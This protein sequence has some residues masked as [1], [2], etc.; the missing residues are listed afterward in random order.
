[1]SKVLN[2][3]GISQR[4]ILPTL[5]TTFL[6]PSVLGATTGSDQWVAPEMPSW[7]VPAAFAIL[8][9]VYALIIFELV[10]RALAA[11][12]GGVVVVLALHSIGD[13]P[14]LGT[15]VTWIDEETIGLLIGM[16]VIVDILGKTG[17]FQW[18]AVQAYALSGG[19]IW[20]L[21]IILCT[22]TAVFS[23]FL[24]NVT[25]ILLIVPVTIQIARVLDI[26]PI[27]LIIAEVMFSNIGGAAT[28]IGDPPNIII[29]AQLSPQA[30]SSNVILAD[31]GLSLI[32]I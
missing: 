3:A 4:L 12:I 19:S 17:L 31:Q 7:A 24:D 1:M 28:Q 21:S 14:D 2:T 15:V 23:A 29:G 30:L 18:A 11:A 5:L 32:H 16:M 8:L 27:P 13:G 25:T 22:I 26:E 9:G 10:H 6:I 20:R